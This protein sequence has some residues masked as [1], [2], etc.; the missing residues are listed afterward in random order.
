MQ[1]SHYLYKH[2]GIYVFARDAATRDF[3]LE[4][5][6]VWV[7]N[8]TDACPAPLHAIIDTTPAWTPIVA[9]LANLQPGGRLVINAIRKEEADKNIL[10]TLNYHE[11][12]WQEKE[13]KSVANITHFDIR[14][15]LDVAAV[16]PIKPK[17]E[18]YRLVEANQALWELKSNPTRGAKVL[19]VQD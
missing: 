12:L 5:G 14:E 13:L 17:T 4:S 16:I 2:T 9:A 19:L 3:A 10:L 18:S 7:G 8:S 6:A 11:H 15:F 1:L